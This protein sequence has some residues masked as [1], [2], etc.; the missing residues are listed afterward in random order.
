MATLNVLGPDF[1]PFVTAVTTASQF[2]SLTF[3]DLHGLLLSHESLL[4]SHKSTYSLSSPAAFATQPVN[5]RPHTQC[6]NPRS[7]TR[8]PLSSSQRPLLPTP[9]VWPQ[10][11]PNN[12]PR[13]PP[14]QA[15]KNS[16]GPRPPKGQNSGPP[17]PRC[18][19]CQKLGHS[20]RFCLNR[21][22]ADPEY[23]PPPMRLN[24]RQRFRPS[25]PVQVPLL[26]NGC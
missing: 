11:T 12:G 22:D 2:E 16:A 20:A 8:N 15:N 23:V 10:N 3:A 26:R 9:P 24:L 18:Q 25:P 4:Q 19:I 6:F 21:F 1:L 17:K 5:P 14:P 13:F 7:Q